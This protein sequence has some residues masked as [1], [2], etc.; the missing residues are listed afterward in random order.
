MNYQLSLYPAKGKVEHAG[1]DLGDRALRLR[2]GRS[3]FDHLV[4]VLD[5]RQHWHLL[6][7]LTNRNMESAL[8]D[9]ASDAHASAVERSGSLMTTELEAAEAH[10]FAPL[11]VDGAISDGLREVAVA[12]L[13]AST[14]TGTTP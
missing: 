14:Q 1:L 9:K 6:T 12:S 3:R 4:L 11:S 2:L 13:A 10:V 5:L 7:S 8:V